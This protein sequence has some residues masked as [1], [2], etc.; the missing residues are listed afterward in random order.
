M[1]VRELPKAELKLG[2]EESLALE[3]LATRLDLDAGTFEWS[4]HSR[5]VDV[6]RLADFGQRLA[7]A[8]SGNLCAQ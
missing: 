1:G 8:A 7:S 4:L 6:Q 2:T 3:R 5:R